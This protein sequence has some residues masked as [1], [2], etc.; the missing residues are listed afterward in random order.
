MNKPKRYHVTR[1]C[2]T[3]R[4]QATVVF[5][6]PAPGGI[7]RNCRSCARRINLAAHRARPAD[8]DEVV[9]LRLI[10]GVHVHSTRAERIEATKVIRLLDGAGKTMVANRLHIAV[11]TAERYLTELNKAAA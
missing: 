8:I 2:P 10:G 1:T 6:T 4:Q 3:C 5:S 9:V 11:R 7:T